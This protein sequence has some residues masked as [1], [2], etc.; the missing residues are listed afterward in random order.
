MTKI[1]VY[2]IALNEE[3]HVARWHESTQEAD[4]HLIADTGS[5]DRTIEIARD[6]GI[7][8]HQITVNPWR[9]DTSRNAAL[10]LLPADIDICVPLDLDEV[11]VPG[12]RAGLE[13]EFAKGVTRPRYEYVFNWNTDGTPH[14]SFFASKIHARHGYLWQHPIH[15]IP[16][17]KAPFVE[18]ESY[19]P[20]IVMHHRP[21]PTKSRG[22]YLDLLIRAVAEDPHS[23]RMSFYAGRELMF[24]KRYPEA[25]KEL[26]R[27]L[28]MPGAGW[29]PERAHTCR[30]L[31]KTDAANAE[32]WLTRAIAE[33]TSREA[34]AERAQFYYGTKQWPQCLDDARAGMKITSQAD[35]Q[36]EGWAWGSVLPDLGSVAAFNMNRR[37]EAL[38]LAEQA[39]ALSPGDERIAANL[40]LL[41]AT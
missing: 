25:T 27:Y 21:D 38:D 33:W 8:L 28:E 30:Y 23:A 31:A 26:T 17:I 36:K 7:E 11:M 4:L 18:I 12:W 3:K 29:R 35:Y 20:D 15:E 9:F 41:K 19:N 39:A 22:S 16:T 24:H 34:L 40:K 10:A 1:A 32:F 13:R 2:A 5:T 14:L 6:R 37:A